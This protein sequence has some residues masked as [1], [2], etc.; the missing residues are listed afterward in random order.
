MRPVVLLAQPNPGH[1]LVNKASILPGA[2]VMGTINPA[3]KDKVVER[4]SSTFEPS[5]DAAAGRFKELE[6][7]P[8]CSAEWL[9]IIATI[10]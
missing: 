2:D 8:T 1:P 5:E 9:R 3:R 6:L 10:R 4:A 7:R